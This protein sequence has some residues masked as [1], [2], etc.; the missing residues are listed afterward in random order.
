MQV[1]PGADT[2]ILCFHCGRDGEPLSVSN[3]RTLEVFESFTYKKNGDFIVSKTTLRDESYG[4]YL[5][6]WEESWSAKRDVDQVVL[7]R[8]CLMNPFFE[9]IE[10]SVDYAEL[11]VQC[12]R[13]SLDQCHT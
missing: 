13:Q 5:E 4:A 7:I 3:R 2:N 9:S 1:A 12:L 10:S 8:L 6:K 11:F